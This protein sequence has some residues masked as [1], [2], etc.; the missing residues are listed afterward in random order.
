MVYP[1]D[2]EARRFFW[3]SE[4]EAAADLPHRLGIFSSI[5]NCSFVR[6][7][8]TDAIHERCILHTALLFE[9]DAYVANICATHMPD[10][11]KPQKN[12]G[13]TATFLDRKQKVVELVIEYQAFHACLP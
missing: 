12:G 11:V 13:L 4:V 7:H 8:P 1:M 9:Q 5:H 2:C 3:V 6:K 10:V